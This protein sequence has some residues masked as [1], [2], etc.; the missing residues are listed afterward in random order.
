MIPGAVTM[1]NNDLTA[2]LN[3]LN[4]H[5]VAV[6]I[7][8]VYGK[9]GNSVKEI[10]IENEGIDVA[11]VWLKKDAP[12]FE[13]IL[14]CHFGTIRFRFTVLQFHL[15]LLFSKRMTCMESV[16]Q[17]KTSCTGTQKCV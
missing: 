5:G 11:G 9:I 8:C 4:G 12:G 16:K 7:S 15:Y 3:V 6:G 13:R 1:V 17:N 2:E 14:S 10:P